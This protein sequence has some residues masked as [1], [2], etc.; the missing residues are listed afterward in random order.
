M[1]GRPSEHPSTNLAAARAHALAVYRSVLQFDPTFSPHPDAHLER[2]EK[3]GE[4]GMGAVFRV[5]DRRL[6]RDAALKVILE[7][8][9]GDPEV[10]RRFEREARITAGLDHPAVPPVHDT[11][12]DAAGRPY[13]LM[14]V[15]EGEPLS[16]RIARFHAGRPSLGGSAELG[17]LVEILV[18]V[19]ET[20]AYAHS[21]GIVHRDL[22]PD[23][24]MVGQFGEVAVM[25]WGLARELGRTEDTF[26]TLGA[27]GGGDG[28]AGLTQVGAVIGTPGYL[29]PEQA[30]GEEVDGRADVF[31][32]GAILAEILTGRPPIAGETNLNRLTATLKGEIAT[33][34]S[35]RRDVP[36]ELD[37]IAAAA[38]AADRDARTPTAEALGADLRAWLGGGAVVAHRYGPAERAT[39]WAR[40]H[41]TALVGAAASALLLAVAGS[42]VVVVSRTADR[43]LADARAD[44]IAAARRA[45]EDARAAVVASS[46]RGAAEHTRAALDAVVAATARHGLEPDEPGA[47]EALE[48]A[49]SRLGEV[50]LESQQWELARHAFE[51]AAE[52]G[53]D[54]TRVAAVDDARR[55]V[56]QRLEDAA[57]RRRE[58]IEATLARAAAGELADRDDFVRAVY[59]ILQAAG[60][61][62]GAAAALLAARLDAI[63]ERLREVERTAL[64]AV[65]GDRRDQVARALARRHAGDR[66]EVEERRILEDAEESL[67]KAARDEMSFVQTPI[68][69]LT[70]IASRQTREVGEGELAVAAVACEALGGLG[71]D[72]EPV[73]ALTRY[74]DVEASGERAVTAGLALCRLGGPE[75]IAALRRAVRRLGGRGEFERRIGR[76]MPAGSSDDAGAPDDVGELV[77]RARVARIQGRADDARDLLARAGELD[78]EATE[79]RLEQA[80]LHLE[81]NRDAAALALLDRIVGEA[82][83][84]AAARIARGRA[85]QGVRRRDEA[86]EELRRGTVLDPGSAD[87]WRALGA[88]LAR[89]REHRDEAG[90]ALDRAIE[91]D[92]GNGDAWDARASL[93]LSVGDHD[94]A[95]ADISRALRLDPDHRGYLGRRSR[96]R[97]EMGDHPGAIADAERTIE[98]DPDSMWSHYNLAMALR[99]AKRYPESLAEF[100]RVVEL[101]P[102]NAR[103]WLDRAL[104]LSMTG[105]DEGALADY[106]RAIELDPRGGTG[107]LAFVNRG[108]IFIRRAEWG[109]AIEELDRALALNPR[110]ARALDLRAMAVR[111]LGPTPGAKPG[112]ISD[113]EIATRHARADA[114]MKRKDWEA[115]IAEYDRIIEARPDHHRGWF[116]RGQCRLQAGDPDGGAADL[117]R[118]L[119][120]RPD[121]REAEKV[122]VFLKQLR[123]RGS[124]S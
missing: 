80:L 28:P 69:R 98:L 34:G 85:L 37:S 102:R 5:H 87:G 3:L 56:S 58:S 123:E 7:H 105:D 72:G 31:A 4:G 119:E 22:K 115:A 33:P 124:G 91:L 100:D 92:G 14:R 13:M 23:N 30:D 9:V 21:R 32:L 74:L 54:D 86:I 93:R 25:D 2:G 46:G 44:R 111:G 107:C 108:G 66:L 116:Y 96:I 11:G 82:P 103:A 40:R 20:V 39:R 95:H 42:A 57:R 88:A 117:E 59:E 84:L 62:G 26:E 71:I 112:P 6:G 16:R 73:A 49:S 36:P 90:R 45:S 76:A 89:R 65:V 35:L 18:R 8:Q 83:S 118:F 106:A 120:L 12:V 19:A 55:A 99:E 113:E 48:E 43:A 101:G 68:K 24:V 109:R 38:L 104:V 114:L 70:V 47:R 50:A 97:R 51:R 15:I 77:R 122:R 121:H 64:L 67:R 1:T 60:Q 27:P 41:P 53:G 110:E 52:L 78:A 75:A 94:G 29:P 61:D 63:T 79:V 81:T 17:A 10:R